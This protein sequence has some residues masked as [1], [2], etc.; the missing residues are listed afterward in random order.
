MQGISAAALTCALVLTVSGCAAWLNRP[1]SGIETERTL[2]RIWGEGLILPS[3][4]DTQKTAEG[5][6]AQISDYRAACP[7]YPTP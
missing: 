4:A 3:R 2:C 1:T 6:T 7:G 5:L